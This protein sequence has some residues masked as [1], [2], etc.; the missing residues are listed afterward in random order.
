M[1]QIYHQFS[2]SITM[3]QTS[4]DLWN[5][6]HKYLADFFVNH[7]I[8]DFKSSCDQRTINVSITILGPVEETPDVLR[9]VGEYPSDSVRR[10]V[11]Y[12]YTHLTK[13]YSKNG[14]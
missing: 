6:L 13:S 12:V 14:K 10:R 5:D 4:Q 1:K 9:L 3:T 7:K 11:E 8:E 2:V